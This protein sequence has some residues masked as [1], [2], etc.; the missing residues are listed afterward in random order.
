MAS[1]LKKNHPQQSTATLPKN[2]PDRP[3]I[4][5][6]KYDAT[7]DE[8]SHNI[9]GFRTSRNIPSTNANDC[10]ISNVE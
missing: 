3:D 7:I 9:N 6:T 5:N 2:G 8:K 4:N 10:D 1:N